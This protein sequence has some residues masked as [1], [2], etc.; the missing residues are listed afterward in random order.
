MGTFKIV[1]VTKS[2]DPVVFDGLHGTTVDG[3][4]DCSGEKPCSKHSVL[5]KINQGNDPWHNKGGSWGVLVCTH[6]SLTSVM[7]LSFVTLGW[8]P[9][10]CWENQGSAC[11]DEG[12]KLVHQWLSSL[13]MASCW[14]QSWSWSQFSLC[15]HTM[16]DQCS[17]PWT[18]SL[19]CGHDNNSAGLSGRQLDLPKR[20]HKTGKINM[21]AHFCAKPTAS[22]NVTYLLAS[23]WT[24]IKPKSYLH[25]VKRWHIHWSEKSKLHLW[26]ERTSK[27]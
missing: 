1:A 4:I 16:M 10:C 3:W 12:G 9:W 13:F 24:P 6:I 20:S 2:M 27:C 22:K 11:E 19:G 8:I 26:V 17:K 25:L 14:W 15:C 5:K 21:S 18:H 7:N 23:M